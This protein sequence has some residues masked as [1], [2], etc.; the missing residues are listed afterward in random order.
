MTLTTVLP[1]LTDS[2]QPP[3]SGNREVVTRSAGSGAYSLLTNVCSPTTAHRNQ[4]LL[5]PPLSSSQIQ[6]AFH[7]VGQSGGQSSQTCSKIS[8][9]SVGRA[10]FIT[11]VIKDKEVHGQLICPRSSC[12]QSLSS[13]SEGSH[14]RVLFD[15][16]FL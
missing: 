8:R 7:T 11:H 12:L 4:G 15:S 1:P 6:C 9:Y 10:D 13:L 16:K 3:P 5:Q 2:S 14:T